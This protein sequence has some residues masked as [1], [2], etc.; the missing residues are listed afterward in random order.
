MRYITEEDVEKLKKSIM[1]AMQELSNIRKD[2]IIYDINS[3]LKIKDEP[4]RD[5]DNFGRK[6]ILV[7]KGS[8]IITGERVEAI[9]G[10][11][12]LVELQHLFDEMDKL[13]NGKVSEQ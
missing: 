11:W 7:K 4:E 1:D 10:A 5:A 6:T 12:D 8:A 2:L 3:Y 13:R 9:A